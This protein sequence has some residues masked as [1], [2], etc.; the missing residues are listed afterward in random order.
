MKGLVRIILAIFIVLH[1]VIAFSQVQKW[2]EDNNIDRI[3]EY[4]QTSDINEPAGK[5]NKTL[6]ILAIQFGNKNLVSELIEMGAD[7][8]VKSGGVSPL[9]YAS[10]GDEIRK[11]S[12]LVDNAALLEEE[13]PEGNTPL[14]YAISNGNLKISKY[15]VKAGASLQHRNNEW[16]SPYDMAIRHNKQEVASYLRTAYE[17]NLP[18]LRDGPYVK[19]KGKKRINA[20]YLV[21]DASRGVTKRSKETLKA[22]RVPFKLEGFAGDTLGYLIDRKRDPSPGQHKA[23]DRVMVIGDIHGGYDSLFLFLRNNGVIDGSLNWTWGDGHLVFVGDI[24]DRGEKVTEALWLIY[25][26]E[27]QAKKSGGMVHLLLGNHEIMVLSGDLYYI[28]DKYRLLTERLNIN[29]SYLFS[30]RT[31][32]GQ[33]LRS[34]NTIVRINGHLFVHAGLSPYVTEW[35]LNM[36]EINEY[37][38]YFL[39]HPDRQEYKDVPRS[40]LLGEAGPFWYRGYHEGNHEYQYLSEKDFEKVI[41]YFGANYIFIG[42]TNVKEIT[43]LYNERVFAIDVPFYSYGYSMYGLLLENKKVYQL[44][45]AARKKLIK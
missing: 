29:Y 11:V 40:S 37:A 20:L 21:H 26:L 1:P 4:L 12:L 39:N 38:R 16:L 31:V 45:T 22:D 17:K 6:L 35:G 14:Y 24:F 27:A 28:A 3:M 8:N 42:H 30:K 9:M 10:G 36:E 19:W 32:L 5:N 23:V 2:V 33:W 43:S 34:R 44:N 15:L 7:V 18:G 25:S 13:D 41:S